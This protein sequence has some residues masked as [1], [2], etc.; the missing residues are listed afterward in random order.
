MPTVRA[1]PCAFSPLYSAAALHNYNYE[2]CA[3]A[4][5]RH[6]VA[7]CNLYEKGRRTAQR[8]RVLLLMRSS[9]SRAAIDTSSEV[10]PDCCSSSSPCIPMIN[11]RN[12]QPTRE[13]ARSYKGG[14]IKKKNKK[15]RFRFE[16]IFSRKPIHRIVINFK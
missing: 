15:L 16:E 13:T 6:A 11:A 9:D 7:S 1:N 8:N 10:E 5:C 14:E 2:G 4:V 12:H 3:C